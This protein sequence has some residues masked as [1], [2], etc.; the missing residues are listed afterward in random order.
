MKY[1]LKGFVV[2]GEIKYIPDKLC[3]SCS[4]EV[5]ACGD[6]ESKINPQ[7]IKSIPVPFDCHKQFN[8]GQKIKITIETE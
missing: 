5:N 8:I 6:L 3:P 7:D 1:E 4:I 2:G